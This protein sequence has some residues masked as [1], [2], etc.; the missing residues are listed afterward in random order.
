MHEGFLVGPMMRAEHDPSSIQTGR[1]A[2]H[3]VNFG[4]QLGA[5]G[6]FGESCRSA[7]SL[8][9]EYGPQMVL[10]CILCVRDIFEC[11]RRPDGKM[12]RQ[13]RQSLEG[14]C[15]W[16]LLLS[17]LHVSVWC[18]CDQGCWTSMAIFRYEVTS[19]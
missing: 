19:Q 1:M 8:V 9:N 16:S 12:S 4:D 2:I 17:H 5:F 11:R 13:R 10:T 7:S 6:S 14:T 3:S 18:L 15:T